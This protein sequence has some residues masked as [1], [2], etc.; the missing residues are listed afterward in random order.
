MSLLSAGWFDHP[1]NISGYRGL[2]HVQMV[3]WKA[4]SSNEIEVVHNVSWWSYQD[5][6]SISSMK[7]ALILGEVEISSFGTDVLIMGKKSCSQA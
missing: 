3:S 4:K 7:D 5:Q 1:E 6:M 2:N